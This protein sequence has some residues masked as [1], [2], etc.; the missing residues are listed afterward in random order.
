MF[1]AAQL[2]AVFA[3]SL[4]IRGIYRFPIAAGKPGEIDTVCK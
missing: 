4:L 2:V 3:A 1:L